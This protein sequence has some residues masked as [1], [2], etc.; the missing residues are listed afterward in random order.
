MT[1]P[2]TARPIFI[3]GLMRSGTTLLRAM[4]GQHRD[5]AAGLETH[6]F[7]IDVA[8]GMARKD[9]PLEPYVER[10]AA[11]FQMEPMPALAWLRQSRTAE[12]FLDRFMA[13]YAGGQGKPRWAEKTPGNIRHV[14]R[15]LAHWPAAKVVH[16]VRDPRDVFASFRRSGRYGGPA[17]HGALWCDFFADAAAARAEFADAVYECRYEALVRDPEGEMRRLLAF[18]GA[19]WDPAAARFEGRPQEFAQVKQL[20]GHESTTL[21]QLADPLRQDRVGGWTEVLSP[22]DVDAARTVCV[23]RG[24]GDTFD[25][26]LAGATA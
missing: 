14:G 11:F 13:A 25:R 26:V 22:A 15:I 9:E 4:L 16:I 2:S 20:T 18:V 19:A 3:G 17:D 12:D 5:I 24:L 8:A 21:A 1:E 23:Q 10:L 7:D 6:W